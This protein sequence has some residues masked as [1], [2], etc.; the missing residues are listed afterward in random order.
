MPTPIKLLPLAP[1]AEEEKMHLIKGEIDFIWESSFDKVAQSLVPRFIETQLHHCL[2]ESSTSEHAAR[3]VSMRNATDNA[4]EMIK[5]L[6]LSFN[7]AR[8]ASITKELLDIIGGVEALT[9]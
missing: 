6:T 3:M 7:K 2:I 8:Q 4:T 1:L 5:D 9:G